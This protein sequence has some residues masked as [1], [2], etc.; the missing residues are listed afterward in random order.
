MSDSPVAR[1]PTSGVRLSA[2]PFFVEWYPFQRVFT[3]NPKD[4][5]PIFR[6][7]LL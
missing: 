6:V 3:G 1:C 2:L 4:G 5:G 7:S